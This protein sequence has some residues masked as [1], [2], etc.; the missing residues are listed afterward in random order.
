[1]CSPLADEMRELLAA[2]GGRWDA[3]R[4]A[5]VFITGGTGFFGCWLLESFVWA[6]RAFALGATATVLS[7]DP[8][9]F[10]RKCPW[11]AADP[12]L[13]WVAGDVRAFAYPSGDFTHIIHAA[14]ESS[15]PALAY[16][17]LD[18]FTTIVEGTRRTLD[19]AAGCGARRVL[20][21][22]SGAVYGPQPAEMTQ[23]PE[24]YM[25]AV[26][27]LT[28][29]ATY[30]VAKCAAEQLCLL[31]AQREGM[32]IPIARCFAF[33]GAHL[34]LDRHFAIGNFLRDALAGGPIRVQGDGTPSRSYLY[35]AEL[36]TWL[37]EILLQGQSGRAYNVGSQRA[38]S[39]A[40]LAHTVAEQCTPPCEVLIAREP[41]PGKPLARYVPSVARA[42]A[43][44]GLVQRVPLVDAIQ[45][46]LKWHRISRG[47]VA[48]QR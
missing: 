47:G 43:E 14:V 24:E 5:R 23:M 29:A 28:P 3:L 17:P 48:Y 1:M 2:T 27:V 19:F 37:W 40:A 45:R 35:A 9:A 26:A 6:N 12:A 30:A 32:T 36:A 42:A 22:S 4:G 15:R 34:P 8:G 10:A 46:T 11:L 16:D 7:R 21:V 44:L 20:Y 33:V 25:G 31:Y 39:I 41:T 18:E 38:V 13:T